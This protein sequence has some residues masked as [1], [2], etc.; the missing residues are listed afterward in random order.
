MNDLELQTRLK[1][2]PLPARP[3]EYWEDFPGRI[4]WQ[5]RSRSCRNTARPV[6]RLGPFR[7]ADFALATALV[8]LFCLQFNALP[9]TCAVIHHHERVFH[10]Q[11]ARLDAGLHKLM[12]NTDG[13]NDLLT[14]A[15]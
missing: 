12:L 13:M 9:L 4:G 6:W 8:L 11:L 1:S 14:D 10:A 15:N 7:A 5:L 2:T 3:D